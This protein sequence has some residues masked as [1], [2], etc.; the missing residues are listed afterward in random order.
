MF[1]TQAPL[2]EWLRRLEVDPAIEAPIAAPSAASVIVLFLSGDF[3]LECRRSVYVMVVGLL[4]TPPW[5]SFLG[6]LSSLVIPISTRS[7]E[8]L[9]RR[10]LW[11]LPS[12]D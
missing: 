2:G 3:G 11:L 10:G 5:G 7:F 8:R 6:I 4:N 12:G 9:R 1:L